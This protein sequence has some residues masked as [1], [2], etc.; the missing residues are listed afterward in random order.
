MPDAQIALGLAALGR[1]AYINITHGE[2][3][4]DSSVEQMERTAHAAP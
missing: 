3:V 2:D 4:A 1:P